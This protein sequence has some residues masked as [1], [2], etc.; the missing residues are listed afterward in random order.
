[1]ASFTCVASTRLSETAGIERAFV[2]ALRGS[3]D[4][5]TRGGLPAKNPA[6]FL[7]STSGLPSIAFV[8]ILPT[9]L[10]L[11][12]Q[13]A[14]ELQAACSRIKKLTSYKH[15]ATILPSEMNGAL[16]ALAA[17]PSGHCAVITLP[18]AILSAAAAVNVMTTFAST[19]AGSL[20]QMESLP[21]PMLE[22]DLRRALEDVPA[23][24]AA[25]FSDCGASCAAQDT[26]MRVLQLCGGSLEDLA[27]TTPAAVAAHV[28]GLS[29]DALHS[30]IHEASPPARCLPDR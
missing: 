25:L 21:R 20:T 19:L 13:S 16:A 24:V 29:A 14:A 6:D 23:A 12:A 30:A 9:Q 8:V 10:A 15:C 17:A 26:A 22:E 4:L 18:S 27:S 2:S 1:M 3:R 7:F 28:S 5:T 11:L